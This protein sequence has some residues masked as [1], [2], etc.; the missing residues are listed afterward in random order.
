[1]DYKC[2]KYLQLALKKIN[3]YYQF[4]PSNQHRYIAV[5]RL[6]I[7]FKNHLLACLAT[8]DPKISVLKWDFLLDQAELVI[9]SLRNSRVNPSLCAHAYIAGIHDFIKTPLVPLTQKVLSMQSQKNV[10]RGLSFEKMGC[11]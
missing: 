3:I 1:M 2:S 10:R 11:A 5:E 6:I 4:V 7:T 9:N 8:C